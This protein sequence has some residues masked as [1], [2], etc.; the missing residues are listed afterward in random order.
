MPLVQTRCSSQAARARLGAA[1]AQQLFPEAAAG[2]AAL[3]GLWLYFSCWQEAHEVAQDIPSAEGS[4]WHAI[5]HRQEPDA[6]NAA[7]WFQR[8]GSHQI[9]PA[10]AAQARIV[11]ERH[12]A[13]LRIGSRWDPNHFVDFCTEAAAHPGSPN[14]RV[15]LEIQR[16]EWQLLFDFCARAT[17]RP[18]R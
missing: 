16:A 15:A 14:E 6:G 3:S 10:L 9:F 13:G 12:S 2:Q 1:S 18:N 11:V 17:V 5:V 8:V 4:Y 7:Y